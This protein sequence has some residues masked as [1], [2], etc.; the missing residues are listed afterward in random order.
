M[1]TI[2]AV[3]AVIS[4]LS[5]PFTAQAGVK[6]TGQQ[7]KTWFSKID[8][9]KDGS[10]GANENAAKYYDR[11]TLGGASNDADDGFIMSKAFFVAECAI[12]SLGKPQ[13]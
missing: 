4:Y 5:S 9:N 2:F 1:K 7:C 3:F 6:Y 8:R 13:G 11:I 10:I 12:G